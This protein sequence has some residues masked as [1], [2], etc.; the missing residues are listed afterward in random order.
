MPCCGFIIF[1]KFLAEKI[2][3]PNSPPLPHAKVVINPLMPGGNGLLQYQQ[4]CEVIPNCFL[5]NSIKLEK[6]QHVLVCNTQVYITP[7]NDIS[8]CWQ[9]VTIST[10]INV[11]QSTLCK[12]FYSTQLLVHWARKWL[13]QREFVY[14]IPFSIMRVIINLLL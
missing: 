7:F 10:Q 14:R 8:V 11:S 1:H 13:L 6:Q 9:M 2:L 4:F 12:I 5:K 3:T